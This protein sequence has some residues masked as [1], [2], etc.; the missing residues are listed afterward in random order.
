[1][2]ELA[3]GFVEKGQPA[4]EKPRLYSFHSKMDCDRVALV[5]PAS[6]HH[7]G[8]EVVHRRKVGSPVSGDGPL[9]NRSEFGIGA[10]LG[11]EALNQMPDRILGWR[12]ALGRPLD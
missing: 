4:I 8:P 2:E 6:A 11:V 1:M 5:T 3:A 9:E 7:R 12:T 10:D